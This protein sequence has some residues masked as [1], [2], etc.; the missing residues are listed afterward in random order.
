M[1]PVTLVVGFVWVFGLGPRVRRVRAR[2]DGNVEYEVV[3]S[4][5]KEGV[6]V[7]T[8]CENPIQREAFRRNIRD[9]LRMSGGIQ[10]VIAGDEMLELV[11]LMTELEEWTVVVFVSLRKYVRD[12]ASFGLPWRLRRR[13]GLPTVSHKFKMSGASNISYL[14]QNVVAKE[15]QQRDE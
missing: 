9:E 2:D 10:S 11:K 8:I 13:H 3:T 1:L 14:A 5:E 12:A 6:R 7:A 15:G 4:I